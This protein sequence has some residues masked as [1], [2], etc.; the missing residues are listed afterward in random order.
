[1]SG[2]TIRHKCNRAIERF[3]IS[4]ADA[5]KLATEPSPLQWRDRINR[6]KHA[7][8]I[9]AVGEHMKSMTAITDLSDDIPYYR[10]IQ[11]D[12]VH[13]GFDFRDAGSSM[14]CAV[15]YWKPCMYM[16]AMH[17]LK[18][19]G[20]VQACWPVRFD[21]DQGCYHIGARSAAS[22][23]ETDHEIAEDEFRA[24]ELLRMDTEVA[25]PVALIK[26]RNESMY[27]AMKMYFYDEAIPS[28]ITA[29]NDPY[30]V[31]Y[32]MGSDLPGRPRLQNM[33]SVGGQLCFVTTLQLR[34]DGQIIR[35]LISYDHI[36]SAVTYAAAALCN[37]SI[38]DEYEQNTLKI[39]RSVAGDWWWHAVLTAMH[40]YD[41]SSHLLLEDI[42][43]VS[44]GG[45]EAILNIDNRMRLWSN[46][47]DKLATH[48]VALMM[49]QRTVESDPEM[50]DPMI[51][52]FAVSRM[53]A[54]ALELRIIGSY[55]ESVHAHIISACEPRSMISEV[56]KDELPSIAEST[57]EVE[58]K[59][60]DGDGE[61]QEE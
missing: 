10:D 37:F 25:M 9:Q 17:L 2:E 20:Y 48:N 27:P 6:A 44:A 11:F 1:M 36:I 34:V 59:S 45:E 24:G 35:F 40:T 54:L 39:A 7:K 5:K 33:E 49:S 53:R 58:E 57:D 50:S 13:E 22:K 60:S 21:G 16:A 41:E 56:F 43:T 55:P 61:R 46:V 38:P 28:T 18:K 26:P 15:Q 4:D 3:T 51:S 31:V 52:Y 14:D 42:E 29:E 47:L 19:H 32:L 23:D 12:K 8:A 30:Q